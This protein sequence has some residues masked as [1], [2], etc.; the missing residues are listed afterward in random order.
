MCK[1]LPS[2]PL[3]HEYVGA[4]HAVPLHILHP[5]PTAW[6]RGWGVRANTHCRS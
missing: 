4:R 3:S 1:G 5:S 6:E 2:P